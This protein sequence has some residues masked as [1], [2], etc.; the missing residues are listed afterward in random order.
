MKHLP[1]RPSFE[2]LWKQ[3]KELHRSRAEWPLSEA[4]RELA[5]E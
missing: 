2:Q 1:A 4:Q 3:A 5:H